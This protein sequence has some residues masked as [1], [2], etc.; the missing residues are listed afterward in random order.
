VTRALACSLLAFALALAAAS[1]AAGHGILRREGNVLRYTAPDPGVGAVLTISSPRPGTLEFLDT[2]SPFGMDWGP[3][4]PITERR[5]KCTLRGVTRIE[6]E[7][8]DG[9]DVVT[10]R[11]GTPVNVAAGAG[12]DRFTGGY[13]NDVLAGGSG[14]DTLAGGDGSDTLDGAEGDD[15][16][17]VRDGVAD[18]VRCG[19]GSDTVTADRD[20]PAGLEC[21]RFGRGAPARDADP[22]RVRLAT[23]RLQR[24]R[25]ARSVGA[26]V[27]MDEPGTLTVGGRVLLGGRVA[28]RLGPAKARPDAPDQQWSLKLRM[29]RRLASSVRR[30][31]AQGRAVVAALTATGRD[32]ARNRG[33]HRRVRV[34]IA[35]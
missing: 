25:R 15:A 21:E 27:S 12:N 26:E 1:P 9:D 18:Q 2:T 3:C 8:Y 29:S 35:R 30:A 33:R 16:M 28:G 22:P 14:S 7:L 13:G 6:V 31:L 32:R 23:R 11:V 20:D 5:S 4:V 24:L 19:S 17:E 34:R 10:A